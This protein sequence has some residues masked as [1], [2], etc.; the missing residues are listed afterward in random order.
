MGMK[1][2]GRQHCLSSGFKDGLMSSQCWNALSGTPYDSVLNFFGVERQIVQ[3]LHDVA[4]T[5][6]VREGHFGLSG[7]LFSGSVV[8]Q[9]GQHWIQ[10]EKDWRGRA[11]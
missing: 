1:S 6:Q 5:D 10:G 3:L 11:A 2:I 4:E 9:E 8:V 7:G